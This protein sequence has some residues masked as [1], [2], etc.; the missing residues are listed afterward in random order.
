MQCRSMGSV[1]HLLAQIAEELRTAY[2]EILGQHPLLHFWA[3]KYDC[4]HE[5]VAVHADF[6]AVNINF[7]ITPD[8]A[9]LDPQSGGLII[10]DKPAPLDWDFTTYNDN[11]DAAQDFLTK[12]NARA[13]TIPYR[14]NRAVIFNSNLF[15]E[16]DKM[17]F[18]E[19]YANRRINLTLLYGRR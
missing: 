18:K 15:H 5:G 9:N 8:D 1:H 12:T 2:P 7:W 6:A 13:I 10:W 17:N 4:K 14:A 3:F 19:G 11:A 16:T